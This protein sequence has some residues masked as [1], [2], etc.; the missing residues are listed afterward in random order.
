MYS[1]SLLAIFDQA[2][3]LAA[4]A[5]LQLPEQTTQPAAPEALDGRCEPPPAKIAR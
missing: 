2:L 3:L 5:H 1:T 4:P